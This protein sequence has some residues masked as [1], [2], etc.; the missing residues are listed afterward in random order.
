MDILPV[1]ISI[2][3]GGRTVPR[4]IADRLKV[5]MEDIY[6][7]SDIFTDEIFDLTGQAKEVLKAVVVRCAVD[8]N[9]EESDLPPLN[10][11]GIIKSHTC[12]GKE[13]YKDFPDSDLIKILLK[14]YYHT[15]HESFSRALAE[16]D[17]ELILDC[18][19][20]CNTA[21]AV[22]PDKGSKRPLVCLGNLN[23]TTCSN[24]VLEKL[25]KEFVRVFGFR[26]RDITFNSPFSGGY[27]AKKYGMGKTPLV[28]IEINRILYI[29]END[30]DFA[31]PY[32]QNKE[33][34]ILELRNGFYEV[35]KGFFNN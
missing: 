3:H 25:K 7:D 20:M 33:P 10:P 6:K 28:Q 2:P 35:L 14:K 19:S 12:H 13:V 1:F 34:K 18:H 8:L 4:E 11:D 31:N 32:M 29:D 17:F 30:F 27:I 23:D 15:Y 9:R 21:P 16:N 26:K 5:S 22:S 24:A